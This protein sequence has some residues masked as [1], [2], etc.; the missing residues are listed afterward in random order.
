[1]F[2]NKGNIEPFKNKI[3]LS[4][5]TMHGDEQKWVTDAFEKNWITTAGENI[6]EVEHLV[7][8]YVGC[9]YAVGLSCGIVALHLAVKLVEEKLYGYAKLN[10][11]HYRDIRCS[12]QI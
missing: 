1:M 3:W 9:K 8:E 2:V 5:P 10:C 6:N 11:E 12:A 4:S 7:A